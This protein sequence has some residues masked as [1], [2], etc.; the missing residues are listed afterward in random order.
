M[1]FLQL[2]PAHVTEW[3]GYL[4]TVLVTMSFAFSHLRTLRL[5]NSAGAIV[6]IVYGIL[7]DMAKPIILTNLIIFAINFYHLFKEFRS[8]K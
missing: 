1:I 2:I 5:V 3:I 4:G 7:L 8:K 6:F